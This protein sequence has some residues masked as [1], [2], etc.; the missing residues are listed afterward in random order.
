[1]VESEDKNLN[2]DI[3]SHIKSSLESLIK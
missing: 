2:R 3:L 1:M